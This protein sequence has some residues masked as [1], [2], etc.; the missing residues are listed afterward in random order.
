MTFLFEPRLEEDLPAA[1]RAQLAAA[2]IAIIYLNA[3][4]N[5]NYR[6]ED[7]PTEG[8]YV[9]ALVG[10][11]GAIRRFSDCDFGD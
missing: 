10:L 11:D 4:R 5:K 3:N 7:R 1:Q 8:C 2:D 6:L 9:L